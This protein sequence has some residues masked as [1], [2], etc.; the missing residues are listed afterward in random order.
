[1]KYYVYNTQFLRVAY[2]R[3]GLPVRIYPFK[4]NGIAKPNQLEQ[5]ISVLGVI[6]WNLLLLFK[7]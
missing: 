2:F 6:G 1:M 7:L 3:L 4:Q 5:F